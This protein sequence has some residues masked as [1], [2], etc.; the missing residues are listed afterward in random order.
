M[1]DIDLSVIVLIGAKA[2]GLERFFKSFL[3]T[4]PTEKIE[5]I[6][7][8]PEGFRL[9]F[10]QDGQFACVTRRSYSKN[11][12]FQVIKQAVKNAKGDYVLFQEN[13]TALQVN[14]IDTLLRYIQTDRY[15]CIG[16]LVYPGESM[17]F[18]DWVA[19]LGHYAGWGPG[20]KGGDDHQNVPG[21]NCVY[22]KSALLDLGEELDLYFYADSI[23]QWKFLEKGLK[24]YLTDE[25]YLIHDDKMT[26]G[27]LLLENFWYGWI[28]SY[29]RRRANN[30]GRGKR[31]FYSVAVFAKPLIRFRHL[32]KKPLNNYPITGSRLPAILAAI[33]LN[34]YWNALGESCGVLFS[35]KLALR[36]FTEVH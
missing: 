4:Q 20:T 17:S 25:T 8:Y 35:E 36:K 27:E 24:L 29:A 16:T 5:I 2:F 15:A 22:K 7:I 21:H 19:Y 32:L 23:I 13:H 34:Y 14:I 11:D 26:F 6:L 30:W 28:F 3:A 31:L 18:T 10:N 9:S 1:K 33:L 12:F